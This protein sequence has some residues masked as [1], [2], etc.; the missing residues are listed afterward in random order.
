MNHLKLARSEPPKCLHKIYGLQD[1]SRLSVW[2]WTA[3]PSPSLCSLFSSSVKCSPLPPWAWVR[4]ERNCDG[5]YTQSAV[6]SRLPQGTGRAAC[7]AWFCSFNPTKVWASR[8]HCR[9]T[10]CTWQGTEI[11]VHTHGHSSQVPRRCHT[12]GTLQPHTTREVQ[13]HTSQHC[14]GSPP[15]H[16]Q[17]RFV[18]HWS[19]HGSPEQL[20]AV[21]DDIPSRA[22]LQHRAAMQ[23]PTQHRTCRL[24]QEDVRTQEQ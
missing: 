9:Q 3:L 16:R 10:A 18:L 22:G 17:E 14:S 5:L 13:T 4:Q 1:R 2:V 23:L 12:G 7:S 6:L 19:M 8:A 20:R 21:Q 15:C 24:A 11:N